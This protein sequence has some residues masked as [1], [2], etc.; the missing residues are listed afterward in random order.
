MKDYFLSISLAAQTTV[1][2]LSVTIR[3]LFEARKSR[4]KQDIAQPDY[5]SED[6]GI[7]TVQY[8]DFHVPVPDNGRYTLHCE[9]DD[10]IVCDKCAK[11]CPVDCI[12]IEAI[13]SPEIIGQ[14]SDGTAKRLH[15]ARFDIDMAKCCF[16][17]LCT[18]VC[19]TE[20]LTMTD[21]YD[22]S[23]FERDAMKYQFAEM[24]LI[25]IAKERKVFEDTQSAKAALK[26][27]TAPSKT[28]N[29]TLDATAPT[30]KAF[31]PFKPKPKSPESAS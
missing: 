31:T 18:T 28:E 1:K 9:I 29:E 15:A 3:H 2:G 11:I 17:G 5:F 26:A 21:E 7:V 25:D 30:K 13:K 12:A 24:S 27:T 8:P 4:L 23:T 10:C 20:C 19:P 6:K 16:C 22:F 14:T